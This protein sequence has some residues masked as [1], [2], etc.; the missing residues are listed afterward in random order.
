[1]SRPHRYDVTLP[2]GRDVTI[3]AWFSPASRGARDRY[4]VPMEPDEPDEFE[5]D[6]VDLHDGEQAYQPDEDEIER[7]GYIAALERAEADRR[8]AALSERYD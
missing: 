3:T 2:D 6:S 4:G 8:D 7:E 1:M 5:I